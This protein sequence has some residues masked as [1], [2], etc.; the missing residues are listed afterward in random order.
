MSVASKHITLS[1]T[2]I[3]PAD[4]N[5]ADVKLGSILVPAS[6]ELTF[7]IPAINSAPRSPTSAYYES[8]SSALREA[9][10]SLNDHLTPW[11]VAIG[12]REK[13]KEDLGKVGYGKGRAA[14]MS[15]GVDGPKSD[16][17]L[18]VDL[19]GN[20]IDEDTD[21]DEPDQDV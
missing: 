15:A 20:I 2:I 16:A 8:A 9:Q 7:P 17:T 6:A 18:D 5:A 3:P 13:S 14:R 19:R 11:K 4:L 21:D 12:D 1:Y 10:S